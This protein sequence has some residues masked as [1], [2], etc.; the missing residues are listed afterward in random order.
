MPKISRTTNPTNL[1][2]L[3]ANMFSV[4][5]QT[6]K[7]GNRAFWLERFDFSA[8]GLA[9]GLRLACVAHAGSTEEYFELGTIDAPDVTPH[10]INELAADRPLKF[11]FVVYESGNPRLSAFA[12]NIRAIDEAGMLGDSLVD[13]EPSDL[14]G[15]AWR[16]EIPEVKNGADK[17]V[18]LV[19][20]QLFPTALA[21]AKDRWVAILIMPEVMRQI[22]RVISRNMGCLEDSEIWISNWADY[23]SSFGLNDLADD[24]DEI[25]VNQWVEDVVRSFCT[26]PTMKA[27]FGFAIA[28][29]IGD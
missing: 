3:D 17:P 28:E 23:I 21:A 9:P 27:Q 25:A 20:R 16:L 22:A 12:D 6:S 13:I 5:I 18:L 19:E 11:R 8:C 15:P 2:E 7:E 10:A 29:L 14:N 4:R 24:A 1:H 26:K